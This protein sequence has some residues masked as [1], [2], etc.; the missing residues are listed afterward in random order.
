MEAHR[1]PTRTDVVIDLA[2]S[3]PEFAT[4]RLMKYGVVTGSDGLNAARDAGFDYVE[5]P[6][7]P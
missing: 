5:I 1:G 4:Q 3:S 7:R 2:L 6:P